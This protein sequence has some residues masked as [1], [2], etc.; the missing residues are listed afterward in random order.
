MT[1]S[2]TKKII[3]ITADRLDNLSE[4]QFKNLLELI[5]KGYTVVYAE[6]TK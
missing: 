3:L 1:I 6:K 2:I 4:E 5:D